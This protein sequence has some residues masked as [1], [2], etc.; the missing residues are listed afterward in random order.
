MT[1]ILQPTTRTHPQMI[2]LPHPINKMIKMAT[3][4]TVTINNSPEMFKI[5]VIS[6]NKE[7]VTRVMVRAQIHSW[8]K[9][10]ILNSNQRLTPKVNV[11]LKK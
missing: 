7:T 9:E 2:K 3:T 4:K 5:T 8:T 11:K 10:E 1:K 6:N